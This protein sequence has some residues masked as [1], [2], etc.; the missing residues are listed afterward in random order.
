MKA[1]SRWEVSRRSSKTKG[2]LAA[3]GAVAVLLGGGSTFALW[4]TDVSVDM[5]YETGGTGIEAGHWEFTAESGTS[6]IVNF[7]DVSPDLNLMH[8]MT[9]G[10]THW[11]VDCDE[12]PVTHGGVNP[13]AFAQNET[14]T[15]GEGD[16][17][18]FDIEGTGRNGIQTNAATFRMVPGDVVLMELDLQEVEGLVLETAELWGQNLCVTVGELTPG[19]G[20]PLLTGT[21]LSDLLVVDSFADGFVVVR[22]PAGTVDEVGMSDNLGSSV[23]T[24]IEL[25]DVTITLTQVRDATAGAGHCMELVM[26]E[27]P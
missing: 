14:D 7:W 24:G 2:L 10:D 25:S 18:L 5:L 27:T 11:T 8:T 13:D 15:W 3:A 12:S 1:K 17:W 23:F 9:C 19:E 21:V 22:F 26:V 20:D 16:L 4:S 6:E